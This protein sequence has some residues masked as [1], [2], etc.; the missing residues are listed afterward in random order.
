MVGVPCVR[1]HLDFIMRFYKN[2]FSTPPSPPLILRYAKIYSRA[3]CIW[4]QVCYRFNE[5]Y[6]I[7]TI[8]ED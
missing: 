5:F 3:N 4:T 2:L 7:R 6:P 8:F 1:P